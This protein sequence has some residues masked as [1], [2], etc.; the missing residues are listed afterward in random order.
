MSFLYFRNNVRRMDR[1][2]H[3]TKDFPDR[4]TLRQHD[5]PTLLFVP[6][7]YLVES[8]LSPLWRHFA[9]EI[10]GQTPTPM[11]VGQDLLVVSCSS[12]IITCTGTAFV[13]ILIPQLHYVQ[14][15]MTGSVY[16]GA[17]S[18]HAA[19]YGQTNSWLGRD[20]K[21]GREKGFVKDVRTCVKS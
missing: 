10:G 3:Y 13:I 6:K 8:V 4:R 5:H 17:S 2:V 9:Y 7:I 12:F 11:M 20:E 14:T 16:T 21:G 15:P 18:M 19:I 1:T